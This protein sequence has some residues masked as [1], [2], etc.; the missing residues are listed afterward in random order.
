MGQ[1]DHL[2]VVAPSLES[3]MAELEQR[4]GSRPS[5]GGRHD[6]RGTQ[7]ALL[8]LGDGRY[9]ELLAPDPEQA[10]PAARRFLGVGD[11][12]ALHLATWVA[13]ASNLDEVSR[14]AREAGVELG[15][16]KSGGRRTPDGSW[17]A[18][19]TL[20]ADASRLDGLIPFFIDWGDT[21][22]PSMGAARGCM[23]QTL[24]AEHPDPLRVR[25]ALAALDLDLEVGRGDAPRLMA[26]MKCPRGV[27]E[28][29]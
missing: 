17:L 9:L 19:R 23:L 3:G 26:T 4:L 29:R 20:G 6:G 2:I 25:S 13:K 5:A 18:W 21:P 8:S 14:Q 1:L 12:T 10:V 27:V 28:L 16:P 11:Q 15:E 24:R 7:N 22:H